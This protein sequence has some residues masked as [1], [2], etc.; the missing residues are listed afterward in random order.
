MWSGRTCDNQ[1]AKYSMIV[2]LA[3]GSAAGLLYLLSLRLAYSPEISVAVLLLGRGVLGAAESFII[4]GA[5]VWAL[6]ASAH[7]MLAR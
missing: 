7:T 1:G 6:G 2:A 3:A 5:A 4:T